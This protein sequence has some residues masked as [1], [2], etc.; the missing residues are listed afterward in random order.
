MSSTFLIRS[1]QSQIDDTPERI[2]IP[3][4]CTPVVFLNSEVTKMR[5]AIAVASVP[6]LLAHNRLSFAHSLEVE[7]VGSARNWILVSLVLESPQSR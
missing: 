7:S 5:D 2:Q 3:S 4:I 6:L 1:G